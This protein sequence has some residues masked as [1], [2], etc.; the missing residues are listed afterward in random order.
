MTI[1]V[2]YTVRVAAENKRGHS[3]RPPNG[4]LLTAVLN[5]PIGFSMREKT[6]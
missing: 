4:K 3:L 1:P 2:F 5:L 6:Y